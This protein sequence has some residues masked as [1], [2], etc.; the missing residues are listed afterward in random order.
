MKK[1][2]KLKAQLEKCETIKHGRPYEYE[3]NHF[4]LIRLMA[5]LL[6]ESW[7]ESENLLDECKSIGQKIEDESLMVDL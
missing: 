7:E 6:V 5:N 1:I 3:A 2:E 4:E